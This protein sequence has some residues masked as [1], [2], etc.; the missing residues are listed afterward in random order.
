MIKLSTVFKKDPTNLGRVVN[1]VNSDNVWAITGD[2]IPTR[3]FDGTACAIIGGY[4]YKRFDLKKGR[5][6]PNNAIP[7]QEADLITGH[8][9]HWVKCDIKDN[10]N[11]WH[12][13]AFDLLEDKEDGTYELCGEKV[14]SNPENIKGHELIK[15]GSEVL[16]F[17]DFS[18]NGIKNF[19]EGAD[20]EGIV[21][22]HK[23]DDRMC[24]IRKSDFGLK[25][26]D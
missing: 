26:N 2:G 13:V 16:Y 17:G 12:F 21:F 6:L 10:S 15:H 25:R 20:I 14:Q 23:N 5:T 19:L 24:K 1:E 11:K 3:K 22:H 4:L 7:C 18:F 9:P 8:H